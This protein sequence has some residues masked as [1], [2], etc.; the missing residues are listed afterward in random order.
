MV[1]CVLTRCVCV[2]GVDRVW[3]AN[4]EG[5]EREGETQIAFTERGELGLGVCVGDSGNL[6]LCPCRGGGGTVF[7]QQLNSV[8]QPPCVLTV[9]RADSTATETHV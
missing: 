2:G 4:I 6:F 7:I 1:V 5:R 9:R 3:Q 8:S